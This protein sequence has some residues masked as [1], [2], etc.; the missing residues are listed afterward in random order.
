MR[1]A[2]D[3][4]KETRF[5]FD[6]EWL[7]GAQVPFAEGWRGREKL[8]HMVVPAIQECLSDFPAEALKKVPLLLCLPERDRP[9]RLSGLD[10]TLLRE[11]ERRL[12]VQFAPPSAV[13][14]DGRMG[15]VKAIERAGQLLA[16]GAAGCV[17]AGVDS[18]LVGP[19]LEAYQ[20]AGRLKTEANS[21]GFLPGE[22]AAAVLVGQSSSSAGTRLLCK[23]L[24][25]GSEPAPI[26]SEEPLRADGL[27]EAITNALKDASATWTDIDYRISDANGEQY[28]FKEAALA[29]TRSM[30]V[31]KQTMD[32]WHPADCIGEV[33]AAVVPCVLGLALDANQKRYGLGPGVLCHFSADGKERGVV[34]LQGAANPVN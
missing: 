34:V 5:M 11:I 1:A 20:K 10:E 15:G 19:T 17:V 31:R 14:A 24:A 30:R 2:I 22:A 9:G 16:N 32:L 21:N 7:T 25:Y 3:A 33:G 28:W 29:L 8:L 6:G 26:L 27:K 4:F 13:F 12:Q 23:G 18:L